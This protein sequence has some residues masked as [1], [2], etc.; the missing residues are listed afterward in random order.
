MIEK[1][2]SLKDLKE[3]KVELDNAMTQLEVYNI[4]PANVHIRKALNITIAS[5]GREEVDRRKGEC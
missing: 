5:I 2:Q 3:I 4:A 1:R